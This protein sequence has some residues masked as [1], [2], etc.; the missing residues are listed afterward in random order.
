MICRTLTAH[1][2]SWVGNEIGL[3]EHYKTTRLEEEKME[4]G[5]LMVMALG[6][7]CCRSASALPSLLLHFSPL[8]RRNPSSS[9]SSSSPSSSSSSS[10]YKT[11]S[12]SSSHN[13]K[14][15]SPHQRD[16]ISLYVQALLQWNQ[17]MNLTA[18]KD[19]TQVMTRHVQDSLSLLSPLHRAYSAKCSSSSTH[20]ISLVDVGS[21]AGL[22]GLILAIACPAWKFT[23]LESMHKRCAFLEHVVHLTGLSNVNIVCDR[24]ENVGQSPHFREAFDV[25]VARAV[26]ELRIL[27]EYCLPLVRVGGLF[28]AAKGNDPQEEIEN[29]KKAVNLLGASILESCSVESHGPLGQRTAV[30][31]FKDRATPR[32]YPRLPGIPSKTPL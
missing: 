25:A 16:Q 23:L 14:T 11:L 5:I 28:L 27:A 15:L 19:Q 29:A 3:G 32:K 4:N 30:I 8:R 24:A 6:N 18:V 2:V 21:G 7:G 9:S 22:P 13:Y 1:R 10:N 17:R 20:S 31:C 26:A 12:A